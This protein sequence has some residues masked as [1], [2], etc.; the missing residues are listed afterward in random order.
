VGHL[1]DLGMFAL[2]QG[3]RTYT[4]NPGEFWRIELEGGE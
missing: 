1:E 4:V 2:S 3:S